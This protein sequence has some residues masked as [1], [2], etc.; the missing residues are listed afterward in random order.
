MAASNDFGDYAGNTRSPDG[1]KT[2]GFTLI[3]GIFTTY[4]FPGSVNTFFYA[5][6]N[7]G[8]AAGH[9]KDID[10]LYHGVILEGSELRQYDFPGAAE[11]HIYGISDETGALSGNIVD[12]AGTTHAFSGE[13]IVTFPGAVQHLWRLCQRRRG[14][15]RQLHRCRWNV[16]W[17][18]TEPRW[19]FH[20]HRPPR[21]A[22]SSIPICKHHH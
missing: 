21:N 12:A 2:I 20:H 10:G 3:D 14:C 4:D 17:V 1:E 7:T 18:H 16:S 13:L 5:L 22:E 11:T 8:K 9:Y 15:R 6:D 19:Q